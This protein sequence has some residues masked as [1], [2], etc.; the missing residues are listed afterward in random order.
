M[1][2]KIIVDSC[3]ELREEYKDDPRFEIIPLSIEVDGYTIQDDA[4]FDQA[5]LLARMAASPECPKSA[6]PAPAAYMEA[7][8]TEADH[9][10]VVTLSS[11]LSGSYNSAM[12]GKEMYE[13]EYGPK[14]IHIVDSETASCGELQIVEELI[15]LEEKSLSF[16]DIVK[17]I[18]HFRSNV[19]TYFVLDN[20]DTFIKTGRIKGMEKLLACKLNIK[21]VLTGVKGV[22]AKKDQGIG[23]GKALNKLV[24]HIVEELK[25]KHERVL[26]ISHCNAPERAE[27]VK[28]MILSKCHF[29][30]VIVVNMRGISSMYANNGGIIV[31]V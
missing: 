18:E 9:V 28:Q 31:T 29:D 19:K 5:D 20:L 27:K 6:C 17:K 8:R 2:Y 24:D 22:I 13:E 7:Y 26:M 14:N 11:K 12:V 25:D 30:K 3:C 15:R 23:M 16:E 4:E 21:P 10:Y 1:N